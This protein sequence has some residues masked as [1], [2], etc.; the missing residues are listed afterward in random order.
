MIPTFQL[1]S[2]LGSVGSRNDFRARCLKFT[3]KNPVIIKALPGIVAEA[4]PGWTSCVIPDESPE[5]SFVLS[6][7]GQCPANQLKDRDAIG[8]LIDSSLRPYIQVDEVIISRPPIKRGQR[9]A[10]YCRVNSDTLA[11]LKKTAEEQRNA[12]HCIL[13]RMWINFPNADGTL[14]NRIKGLN[15]QTGTSSSASTGQNEK[16]EEGETTPKTSKSS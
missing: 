1:N 4:L 14:G 9:T 5:T 8:E 6:V 15:L 3:S 13:S 2:K 7:D 12:V 10:I 11:I 16:K